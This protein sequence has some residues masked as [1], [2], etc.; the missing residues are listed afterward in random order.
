MSRLRSNNDTFESTTFAD[1]TGSLTINRGNATD[2][3]TM[4]DLPDFDANA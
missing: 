3:M 1:P 2:T 4:S